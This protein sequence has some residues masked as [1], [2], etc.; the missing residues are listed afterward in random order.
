MIHYRKSYAFLF[1]R[2]H[3]NTDSRFVFKF[4]EIICQKWVKLRYVLFW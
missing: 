4:H 2:M 3:D 1:Q